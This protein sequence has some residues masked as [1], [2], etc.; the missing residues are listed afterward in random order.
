MKLWSKIVISSIIIV[1]S[2]GFIQRVYFELMDPIIINNGVKGTLEPPLTTPYGGIILREDIP[3]LQK[4]EYTCGPSALLFICNVFGI[5]T[6]EQEIAK[7]SYSTINGT[8]MLGLVKAAKEKGLDAYG[9]FLTISDLKK[10][11]IENQLLIAFI[12][13]NHF[14]VVLGIGSDNTLLLLDPN[15]GK[16]LINQRLFLTIWNG[17]VLYV[18]KEENL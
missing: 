6:S 18:K 10:M 5:K 1:V 11:I 13:K 14:V 7:L 4:R 3:F 12:K 8:S 15:Y 2:V 16:V 17:Y 9:L